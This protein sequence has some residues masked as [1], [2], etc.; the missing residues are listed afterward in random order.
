M[1]HRWS[2]PDIAGEERAEFLKELTA[3]NLRRMFW[4]IVVC[5]PISIGFVIYNSLHLHLSEVKLWTLLDIG[6]G[7]LFLV[8]TGLSL[9]RGFRPMVGRGLVLAYYIYCLAVMDGYYFAALKD[10][11]ENGAYTIG[12]MIVAVLFRL[13]PREFI[14]ILLVNHA[15]YI[16]VILASKPEKVGVLSLM[17]LG[18][19]VVVIGGLAAWFLFNK[20]W[21]DFQK[22]RLI[23]LRNRELAEA[24][25]RL[26]LHN[27][28]MNEIMAI[29]AHDLRSPLYNV[30]ALLELFLTRDEWKRP[31]YQAALKELS[32]AC[33]GMLALVGRL[34]AAHAAEHGYGVGQSSRQ[35]F[36]AACVLEKALEKIRVPA[37]AREIALEIG[38]PSSEIELETDP[39]ALEQVLDNLLSNA[40]K[41]SPRGSRLGVSLARTGDACL[42]EIRDEGSGVPENERAHLFGKFRRGSNPPEEG[43]PGTGLGL[44]IVRRLVENLG[45]TVRYEPQSPCGSAF[46]VNLPAAP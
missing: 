17:I 36:S 20:E 35:R 19:D 1:M 33:G 4:L 38:L 6:P 21:D 2:S 30:K 12:V 10:V 34:L 8:L 9:W 41:F 43:E 27:E 42:F 11:G 45:G 29:A 46:R 13:P 40:L 25:A 5:L 24:N 39:D 22:G 3:G 16:G 37:Q 23:A 28:E 7:L 15:V 32:R 26:Q 44:F 18:L 31:P 14:S